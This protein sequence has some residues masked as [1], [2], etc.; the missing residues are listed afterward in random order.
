LGTPPEFAVCAPAAG[1]PA[2]PIACCF[3][4]REFRQAWIEHPDQLPAGLA[5]ANDDW[6]A[7][8]LRLLQALAVAIGLTLLEMSRRGTRPFQRECRKRRPAPSRR[9]G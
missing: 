5:L 4:R 6:R 7:G 1:V 3:W 8:L 2:G 9:A